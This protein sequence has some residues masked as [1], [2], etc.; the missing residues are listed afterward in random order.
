[1]TM[2]ALVVIMESSGLSLCRL[3]NSVPA[4]VEVSL[5]SMNAA[6]RASVWTNLAPTVTVK[7][8]L[9]FEVGK[10][11][12]N[13]LINVNPQGIPSRQE[14]LADLKIDLESPPCTIIPLSESPTLRLCST[15]A[16]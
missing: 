6:D 14:I 13:P 12:C 10:P 16:H 7:N 5:Q 11:V 3:V 2:C 1:M 15:V 4:V 9:D 8:V